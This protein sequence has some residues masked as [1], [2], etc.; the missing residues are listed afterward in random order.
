MLPRVD[1]L[2]GEVG[3]GAPVGKVVGCAKTVAD[4]D[5]DVGVLV[6]VHGLD[7]AGQRWLLVASVDV[8]IGIRA[9]T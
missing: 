6:S 2:F 3:A 9:G 5:R 1:R 4:F 7:L 8:D